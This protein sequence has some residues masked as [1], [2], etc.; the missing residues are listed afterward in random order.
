[1]DGTA[2]VA[3]VGVVKRYNGKDI[4]PRRWVKVE[5][6]APPCT[7]GVFNNSVDVAFKALAERSYL[8]D[9]GGGN[10]QPALETTWDAFADNHMLDFLQQLVDKVELTPVQTIHEVVDCYKGAKR[11]V[12]EQAEKKYWNDGVSKMDAM[13]RMFVK[14]EKGEMMKAPRVINPR[15]AV[16]NLGLG[17]FLKKNEHA[18]FEAIA[19]IFGQDVTVFKGMDSTRQAAELKKLW[20]SVPN[21]IGIGGDARKFDMHVSKIALMFEHLAYL[22]PYANGSIKE[23][24]QRYWSVIQDDFESPSMY[25]GDEFCELAWYLS[26]QLENIGH[27]YFQ[28]GS[29]HFK[30]HGTRASGDLN[31]SLGNCILM[32]AMTY[33]WSLTCGVPVKLANNGDDCDY[34]ISSSNE[35]KWRTGLEEYFEAKGFRMEL[36]P[37]AREFEEVEFCQS[38]PVFT[39]EGYKMVRNPKTMVMKGTMCLLPVDMKGLRKWMMAVGVAEGSLARGVPVAQAFARCMRRNGRRC[40]QRL[41]GR[42]IGDS[43]RLYHA[44]MHVNDLA[45]TTEA[46]MSFAMAWGIPPHEQAVIERYFD[47]WEM[48]NDFG[49]PCPGFMALERAA[50][51]LVTMPNLLDPAIF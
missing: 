32:C 49:L 44:D 6:L 39:V 4:K 33:A 17:K 19:E 48:G 35:S 40:S 11:K 47:E 3:P 24:L 26:Q 27:G 45:I 15:A 14:F 38:K 12:Y 22:A 43:Q 8:C 2:A 42:V 25:Q 9:L 13:L 1:M 30:L 23:A 46:R 51:N 21:C 34:L 10:F 20:D 41:L 18:Y 37:T 7:L 5:G 50:V 16:Y 31:T 29:V 36:E 28:D